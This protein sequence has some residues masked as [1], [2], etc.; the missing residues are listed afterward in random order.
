MGNSVKAPIVVQPL[1][2][3]IEIGSFVKY[4][5]GTYIVTQF[6]KD[7]TIQIYNP[8]LEGASAKI[9]V[10]RTNLETLS[11]KAKI[12]NYKDTDYIVTSKGTI[13]SLTT[14][15]AMRW[16][17]NDG[18]RVAVLNLAKASNTQPTLIKV[19]EISIPQSRISGVESQ[20]STQEAS[21]KVKQAL[22]NFPYSIDMVEAGFRTRT[23]RSV[24]EMQKYQVKVG[25][26]IIQ[27]GKSANGLI[28]N[29][30]TKITNIH[31]K[32]TEGYLSTWE[33]EGWT[34]EGI[35]EIERYKSGAAAIEFEVITYEG[36][37][38]MSDFLSLPLDKQKVIIEQQ[39][40][41]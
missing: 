17:E 8:L 12:V 26:I 13:I 11:S 16:L 40:N 15:K 32:G 38:P 29:I 4:Q 28:K 24:G 9:S 3:N 37:M 35:T 6:N 14:N 21:A 31:P 1:L 39:L 10:S 19:N 18:N 27:F 20:G 5:G 30:F 23:T 41:C 34:Q 22:G 25:D 2:F 36:N 33:K 7:K